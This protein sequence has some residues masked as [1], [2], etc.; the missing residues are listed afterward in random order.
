MINSVWGASFSTFMPTEDEQWAQRYSYS[1]PSGKTKSNLF[2]TGTALLHLEQYRE[3]A[4]NCSK[5]GFRINSI[6]RKKASIDNNL[7]PPPLV[8]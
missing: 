6:I 2:L 8:A 1:S 3:V 5:L 4:S 7:N